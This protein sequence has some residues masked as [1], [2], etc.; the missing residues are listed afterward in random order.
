MNNLTYKGYQAKVELDARDN[1]LVGRVLG[2]RDHISF[3]GE[4]VAELKSDFEAA[5]EHYLAICAKTGTAPEKPA[6][7]KLLL[8]ISPELHSKAMT[9]AQALG[10]S[11]NQWTAD[12]L[13]RALGMPRLA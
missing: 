3:H 11:L 5:M 1:I 9:T 7:G 6:S 12:V 2:V 13:H 4:T 8:R 10:Q